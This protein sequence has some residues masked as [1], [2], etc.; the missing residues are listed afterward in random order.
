MVLFALCNLSISLPVHRLL[1][2]DMMRDVSLEP[3]AV[4]LD[5][6][7]CILDQLSHGY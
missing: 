2:L 6:N 4:N 7:T 1:W 3:M 5:L